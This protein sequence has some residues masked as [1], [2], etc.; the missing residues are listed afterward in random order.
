MRSLSDFGDGLVGLVLLASLSCAS[1]KPG[2]PA[3][4]AAVSLEGEVA[5][6]GSDPLDERIVLADL[7]G[8]FCALRSPSLEYELRNLTGLRVR[9]TGRLGGR[10]ADGPEL[11]VEKYSLAPVNG[12]EPLIGVLRSSGGE[13]VLV[14]AGSGA[15]YELAGPLA[16]VLRGF[17]GCKV[18]ASGP[19]DPAEQEG[20]D[21]GTLKVESYGVLAPAG[22][23]TNRE[24]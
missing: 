19:I 8:G 21:H 6:I 7:G 10:S 1:Q 20:A 11:L 13:V 15:S 2:P 4:T 17:V 18:W 5:L 3:A 12:R 14:E 22:G 24:P 23:A 16:D 9:V